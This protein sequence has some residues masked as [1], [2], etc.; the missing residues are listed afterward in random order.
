[1]TKT[2]T[3]KK[4]REPAPPKPV[5]NDPSLK[6]ITKTK[7]RKPDHLIYVAGCKN[8]VRGDVNSSV[9]RIKKVARVG[10]LVHAEINRSVE[11]HVACRIKIA[12]L[13]MHS[14]GRNTLKATDVHYAS[15]VE[16]IDKL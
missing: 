10:G 9:E 15:L 5:N 8:V 3:D 13:G 4:K 11:R 16:K 1:M 14:N 12:L 7:K 6:S 2:P